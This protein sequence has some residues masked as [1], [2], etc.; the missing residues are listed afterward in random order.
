MSNKKLTI[1]AIV[2]V[3]T[4]F[5]AVVQSR[6]ANTPRS[7][8]GGPVYLIQGLDPADID[9]IILG[10]GEDEVALKRD[11]G[12]FVV[13]SK[14]N[15]PAKTSEINSLLS[16][17]L[18]IKT[19]DVVTDNPSNHEDLEVTEEKA[20]NVVKLM[21]PEPN[22]TV[23][24]GVVVGKTEE[25]GQGTYVRLLSA[26][27]DSSNKVYVAPSVPWFSTGATSYIEQEL[28]R[29][30]GSRRRRRSCTG[31]RSGREDVQKQRRPERLHGPDE[32]AV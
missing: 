3:V 20:R 26:D 25:L 23:L 18:E 16:K 8:P 2:A 19:S 11:K 27:P 30:E 32:P 15:Y 21:T 1:L 31:E 12:G 10:T 29:P 13:A 24:A 4:V 17:C 7:E 22:S 14:E 6:V 28:V 9:T 5:W